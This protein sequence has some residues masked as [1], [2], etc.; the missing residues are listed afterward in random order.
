M[1]QV[2]SKIYTKDYYLN[3]CLGHEEYRKTKGR[4]LNKRWKKIIGKIQIKKGMK[5]LDLGC[6]RGD[7]CFYLAK[8][9]VVVIGID[10]AKDAIDLA[11]TTLNKMTPQVKKRVKFYKIDAK[12]MDFKNDCFDA[13]IALDF[14]EHLY[15]Q[16]LDIVIGKITKV[17]KKDGFLLAHTEVNKIYLDFT[18]KFY[19]YPLSSVLVFLNNWVFKKSYV[20][21]PKDPR[22][23]YHKKQHVNEPTIFYLKRLF[24]KNLFQG[25]ITQ[26]IG[27]IKPVYKWKDRVYNF[28]V[29]L[30]PLS[31]YYP[32]NIFFC[33]DYTCIMRNKK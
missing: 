17:L 20:D 7:V 9:G 8:R 27:I 10:Y 26:N 1:K 30:Y 29:C 32:L 31:K 19:T 5:V 16:E 12:R 11:K 21:L 24:A 2:D 33:T 13:V 28:F 14:F 18:H 25:R 3:V 15:K 22:N 6:G 23:K 4:N